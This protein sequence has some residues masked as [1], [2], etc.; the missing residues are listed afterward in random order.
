MT[1]WDNL[2]WYGY[3]LSARLEAL[4]HLLQ[5]HRLRWRDGGIDLW[6]GFTGSITCEE[7]PDTEMEDGTHVGLILWSRSNRPLW[8]FSRKLCAWLGHPEHRHP[9]RYTGSDDAEGNPIM[10]DIEDQW[11]CYRCVADT[12]G[13]HE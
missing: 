10:A 1:L 2:C 5:G 4:K 12:K 13:P 7:C 11:Y 6:T 3:G 9:Q 8:W